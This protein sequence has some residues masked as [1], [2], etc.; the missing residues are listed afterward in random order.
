MIPFKCGLKC[1]GNAA[2]FAQMMAYLIPKIH[3]SVDAV[4]PF[5]KMRIV[6]GAATKF[7]KGAV[8]L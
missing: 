2:K 1:F 6:I 8:F 7:F 3:S 5:G 4:L